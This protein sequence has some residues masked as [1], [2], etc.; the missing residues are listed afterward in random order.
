MNAPICKCGAFKELGGRRRRYWW[1]RACNREYLRRRRSDDES[2]VAVPIV[3]ARERLARTLERLPDEYLLD[4]LATLLERNANF[5]EVYI[6]R[7][8]L[9]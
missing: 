8:R 1:C 6:E 7:R 4:R 5:G 9:A 3:G 2:L